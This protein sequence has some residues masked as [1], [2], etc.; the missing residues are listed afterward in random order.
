MSESLLL[1]LTDLLWL[2]SLYRLGNA[3]FAKQEFETAI[4]QYTK[5]IQMDSKNHVF[6]SNRSA[7][8]AGLKNWDKAVEDAKECVRLNPQFMKGY[9]RLATAQLELEEYDAATATIKQGLALEPHNAQLQKVMRNIKLAKKASQATTQ[10]SDRRVDNAT[11]QEL[12]DL[13][14]QL[15]ETAREYNVVKA[16]LSK[17][18]REQKMNQL[19]LSEIEKNPSQGAYFKSVGKIFVKHDQKSILDHLTSSLE[20]QTK[21]ESEI[22]HKLEYL[23]RRMETQQQNIKEVAASGQ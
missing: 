14:M 18:E 6:F 5:A 19:T 12:N 2:W 20:S 9:Y 7:S 8:H 4:A 13:R 1:T 15:A 11:A 3:A 23:E 17:F 21:R 22:K 10:M 16:N